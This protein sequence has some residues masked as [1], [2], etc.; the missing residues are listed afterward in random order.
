M[1][2]REGRGVLGDLTSVVRVSV[3]VYVHIGEG[4]SF[5]QPWKAAKIR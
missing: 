4:V 5:V 1:N 3:L 2:E